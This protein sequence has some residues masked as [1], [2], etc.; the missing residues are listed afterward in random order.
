MKKKNAFARKIIIAILV[1]QLLV[2]VGLSAL[3][4]F[5][6]SNTVRDTAINNLQTIVQERSQIVD[7][8]V[9]ESEVI[10]SSYSQAG[11]ILNIMKN[12]TDEAATNAA[13]KYTESFSA[14]ISNLEGLYASEWDTHVL[15]HTNAAVVGITTRKGDSLKALQ[16][17]MI[18]AN[19]VYNTGIIISPASGAQIVS[20]YQA[21]FDEDG[22][23]AGLVGGGIFTTGLVEKLNN[24]S[25]NG[26][27]HATYC[28]INVKDG[29]YIF[30][31]DEEKIATPVE[32]EHLINLCSQ[33]ADV[34]EDASGYIE[35]TE[36]RN[37]YFGSYYYMADRG[38]LFMINDSKDE[39]FASANQMKKQLLV[40]CSIML[41]VLG[42]VSVVIITRMLNP[43][44]SIENGIVALQKFDVTEN[45]DVE[46]HVNRKD[47]IGN[48][49]RATGDLIQSLR[50]IV[51]TLKECCGTIDEKAKS[52]HVSAVDLVDCTADQ[53]AT[54]EELSASMENT[55]EAMENVHKEI[56]HINEIVESIVREIQ[57]SHSMSQTVKTNAGE[58]QENAKYAYSIGKEELETTRSSV[59]KAIES[60]NG[61]TKINQLATEILSIAN[62]TN[63]LSLNASI[64]AARAGE[65]GK[66]FAVVASEIGTLADTSKETATDIQQICAE[67]N[68]SIEN[69]NKCFSDIISYMEGSVVRQFE[70]FANQSTDNSSAA[71]G[72]QNQL[73][74][75]INAITQLKL[76][77]SQINEHIDEV[78]GI[79]KQNQNAIES[80]VSK[81]E[82]LT[83][84]SDT[85][86]EQ[87]EQNQS[88]AEQ[89]SEIVGKFQM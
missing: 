75:V 19:G 42:V 49:S 82:N 56:E 68:E 81:S 44:K 66:G 85:I 38:W 54:T 6:I 79:T 55:N 45:K 18:A 7:N 40:V 89:F 25:L 20:M 86:Q 11:E 84:V 64:E 22:N 34:T 27:E 28:M 31:P 2:M 83:N 76:S 57:E 15:A 36:S 33:Y 16:D 47:E 80:I 71:E 78:H 1:M 62:Q 46:K 37:D 3:V 73:D 59:E 77:L 65:F 88:I 67:A 51:Q 87:A 12:P 60:L 17:A 5:R 29:M 48:I 26:M 30:N 24:L 9:Q 8:Y 72:I 23:P 52:L 39:L 35:Y 43:M 21:V 63:L 69:V 13:Q 74:E 50:G 58:M 61:L 32:E 41:V 53:M 10:L 14:N 4:V 70:D